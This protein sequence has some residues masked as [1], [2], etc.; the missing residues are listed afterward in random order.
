MP[1][2]ALRSD[3]GAHNPRVRSLLRARKQAARSNT[4]CA[5]D[6]EKTNAKCVNMNRTAFRAGK[7]THQPL[8]ILTTLPLQLHKCAKLVL[9]PPP[10]SRNRAP[11][12]DALLMRGPPHPSI[13]C[14]RKMLALAL[15]SSPLSG[16][17]LTILRMQAPRSLSLLCKP[18]YV[19]A[20]CAVTC[21]R[22]S[23]QLGSKMRTRFTCTHTEAT[24]RRSDQAGWG[25]YLA[26]E[27]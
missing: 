17:C 26:C 27:V 24:Q 2:S 15:P 19:V 12:H 23:R 10:M 11:A 5:L 13:P 8:P 7:C 1:L 18:K 22:S 20:T 6:D 21:G 9:P 16:A 25:Q 14:Q 4:G 3:G